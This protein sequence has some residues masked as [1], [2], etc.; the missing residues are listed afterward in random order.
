MSAA[1][2]GFGFVVLERARPSVGRMEAF[3]PRFQPRKVAGC[4]RG[5]DWEGDPEEEEAESDRRRLG[6]GE[7][8]APSGEPVRFLEM[9]A[10]RESSSMLGCDESI[11]RDVYATRRRGGGA[12]S[13]SGTDP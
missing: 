7:L 11:M 5:R 10:L 8:R 2:G 6:G 12:C 9:A 13:V 1:V 3:T 4:D